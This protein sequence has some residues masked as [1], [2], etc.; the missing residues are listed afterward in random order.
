MTSGFPEGF[1][2]EILAR[3]HNRE[4]FDCG[5]AQVN[6][7]LKNQARQSQDKNLSVTRVLL[8]P[9]GK[10]AGFY[11][12]AAGHVRLDELPAEVARRLPDQ[13]VPVA[14]LAWLGVSRDFQGQGLGEELLANALMRCREAAGMMPFVAVILDCLTESAK[15]FYLRY[16]FSE[17]PGHPMRLLVPRNRLDAMFQA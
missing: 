5:L 6:A 3:S 11:T 13:L 12:L 15:A 1:R 14:K 2:L 7:W 8:D 17:V 9:A 10:I 4:A 16:Q